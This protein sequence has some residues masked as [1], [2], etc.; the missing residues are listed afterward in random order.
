MLF[1][2]TT[3]TIPLPNILATATAAD[4]ITQY[5]NPVTGTVGLRPLNT[6]MTP[7]EALPM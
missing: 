1:D 7:P 2:P 5:R 6:P 3:S 4:P